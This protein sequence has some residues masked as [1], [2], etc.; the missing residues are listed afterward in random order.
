[1]ATNTTSRVART[2]AARADLPSASISTKKKGKAKRKRST[3]R[4]TKV[5]QVPDGMTPEK[6]PAPTVVE[7]SGGTD[8]NCSADSGD[9]SA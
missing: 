8:E 7:S 2:R 6:V 4:H 1:M 3:K 5:T 9:S